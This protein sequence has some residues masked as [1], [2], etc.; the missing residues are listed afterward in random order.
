MISLGNPVAAVL[1][2]LLIG[3]ISNVM[4]LRGVQAQPQLIIKGLL[5]LAAVF[6][7][8]GAG[9]NIR[10]KLQSMVAARWHERP[11]GVMPEQAT[12]SGLRAH[13]SHRATDLGSDQP[14]ARDQLTDANERF[15]AADERGRGR[16]GDS[17]EKEDAR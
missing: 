8:S 16:L 4:D 14:E 9:A 7:T 2:G 3:T 6:M 11:R 1:G 10:A 5:I 13:E 17:S 12:D 15:A